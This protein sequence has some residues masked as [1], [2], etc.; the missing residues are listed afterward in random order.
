MEVRGDANEGTSTF[1][2]LREGKREEVEGDAAVWKSE[3]GFSSQCCFLA[4]IDELWSAL[5][6]V[7][8]GSLLLS[9]CVAHVSSSSAFSDDF[10][11]LSLNQSQTIKSSTGN[12]TSSSATNRAGEG[13]DRREVWSDALSEEFGLRLLLVVRLLDGMR[14]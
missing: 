6:A 12:D 13:G 1:V 11:P 7:L 14:S 9:R 5:V 10:S 8:L 4:L 3:S 2:S